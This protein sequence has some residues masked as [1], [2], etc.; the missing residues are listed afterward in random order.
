M[1]Q[2]YITRR[3]VFPCSIYVR[4]AQYFCS[5]ASAAGHTL[6]I[7]DR[8]IADISPVLICLRSTPP[9]RQPGLLR[10][11]NW[12]SRPEA[13]GRWDSKLRVPR[14]PPR[15]D[16]GVSSPTY[17]PTTALRHG[18]VLTANDEAAEQLSRKRRAGLLFLASHVKQDVGHCRRSR[19]ER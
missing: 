12:P 19:K 9:S 4:L 16:R 11:T 3:L 14:R 13:P 6:A 18:D 17:Y 1:L 5:T 10:H 2:H 7:C 15:R 8:W